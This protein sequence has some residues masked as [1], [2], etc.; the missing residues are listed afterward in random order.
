MAEKV[1]LI[2]SDGSVITM[3]GQRR[4]IRDGSI[5]AAGNRIVGVGKSHEVR[6]SF[7]AEEV[8]D[9]KGCAVMPGLINCHIHLP[10]MLLRGVNDDVD[11]MTKL[12][13]YIWPWQGVY[14]EEDA[15]VSSLLGFLEMLKSGTTSIISTGLHPR[16]GIDGI[17]REL[18]K[19]GMR[20]VVSKYIME[21]GDYATEVMAIHRGLHET[22]E[23][24]MGEAIRLIKTWNGK[25][26]GR[27]SIWFS[28]RSVGAC[29][30][31]TFREIAELARRYG[32][33]ITTHWAEVPNDAEY[34]RKNFNMGI[35][36]F[37]EH[38]GILTPNCTMAH[39][40]YFEDYEIPKLAKSGVN[41]CHCP[42]TNA[43]LA[44]GMAKVPQMLRA[45]VNVCLGTDG[46]HADN[47]A[48]VL[49]DM[50]LM[51]MLHRVNKMDPGY[52]RA[53]DAME[54]GTLNGA[55]AMGLLKELGSIET[56]KKADFILVNLDSCHAVPIQDVVSA[57][58][59]TAT[60]SDVKT[61]VIDGKVVV[62]DYRVMT[63]DEQDILE[64]A[65]ERAEAIVVKSG[66]KLQKKWPT[67]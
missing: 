34:S 10:Q 22:K 5:A 2:V 30:V 18:E 26:N 37:A 56:G 66:I 55:K 50:R 14:D 40:I 62:K 19:S 60:G 39:G 4:I 27:I 28:P 3:D 36:D 38:V 52:P 17:L 48:D 32:V 43:K 58:V 47:T 31:E 24:S 33:G 54:M 67:I 42:A 46:V 6:K 41:I 23:S 9:A 59:W 61:V 1:D 16:Y 51:L 13:K 7:E 53:E 25:A 64:K 44:M 45:G 8:V 20:A 35:A 21:K 11:A 29:S 15:K 63:L 49:R 57:V 12:T 65:Q